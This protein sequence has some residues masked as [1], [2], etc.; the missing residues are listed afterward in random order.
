VLLAALPQ[1]AEHE[2]EVVVW[3]SGP[4]DPEPLLARAPGGA[5][6][7]V[8]TLGVGAAD[9]Q[10]ER[11]GRAW[12]TCLPSTHDSFGM[13]LLESLACG[14]PLVTTT[15][16]A[17]QEL[18]DP[19]ATGE[20]CPPDDPAALAAA[21]LRAFELARRPATAG[22]CRESARPY[23]WDEGLAPL[24]E[25]LYQGRVPESPGGRLT[26]ALAGPR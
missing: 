25:A 3:L 11:Y 20:L 1:I 22:A 18:V 9:A 24:C 7:R 19:G 26:Q 21:C 12:V 17:P 15:H 23:D 10:A 16:S 5:R 6:E 14:T 13:A 2:P 4:G 8:R